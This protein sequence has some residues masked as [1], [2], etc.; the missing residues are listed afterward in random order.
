M[1]HT[2]KQMEIKRMNRVTAL[3]LRSMLPVCA[4]PEQVCAPAMCLS[5]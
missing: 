2:E 5:D 1:V 4:Q 3:R